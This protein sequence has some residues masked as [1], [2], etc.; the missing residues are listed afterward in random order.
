LDAY[1]L[2]AQWTF[3]QIQESRGSKGMEAIG[4]LP[5]YTGIVVHDCYCAYFKKGFSFEHAICN[6]HL[7]RE[8]KGIEE[9]D[10]HQWSIQMQAFLKEAWNQVKEHRLGGIPMG[11][12]DIVEWPNTMTPFWPTES[13]NGVRMSGGK[14]ED[15]KAEPSRAKLEIWENE[16]SCTKPRF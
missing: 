14:S 1:G 15:H 11:E 9:N 4:V 2:R 3:L 13:R 12:L 8:C 6:T 10:G 7:L 5:V 16:C